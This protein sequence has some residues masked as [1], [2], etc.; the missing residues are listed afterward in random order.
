MA[1]EEGTIINGI[2]FLECVGTDKHNKKKWKLRC[3]CGNEFVAIGTAVKRGNTQ[4]CGCT[5]YKRTH[6]QTHTKMYQVWRNM[7]YRCNNVK[8][9]NYNDYGGRGIKVCNDWSNDF[10]K[11]KEWADKN[12]YKEGLTLDRIN[13]NGNYEPENCRWVTVKTQ[14]INRRNTIY[15]NYKGKK[16]TLLDVEKDTGIPY[17]ILKHR[18]YRGVDLLGACRQ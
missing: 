10:S 6:G 4:S 18:V 2:E 3:H 7:K 9:P 14:N 13:N 5:K 8:A 16:C 11:F 1:Y 15:V 17:N 12:G